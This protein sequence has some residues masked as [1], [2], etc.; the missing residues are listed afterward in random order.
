MLLTIS[1]L[2]RNSLE[3]DGALG[4]HECSAQLGRAIEA[5]DEG[6]DV[7]FEDGEVLGWRELREDMRQLN[8]SF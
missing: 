5:G 3:V 4:L 6:L 2:C 1:Q 7:L 8:Q